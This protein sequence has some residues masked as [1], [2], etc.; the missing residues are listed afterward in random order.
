MAG[1]HP[2]LGAGAELDGVPTRKRTHGADGLLRG[3]WLVDD[4]NIQPG[5]LEVSE[6]L[7][8]VLVQGPVP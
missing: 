6:H 4:D 1:Q 3:H 5:L 7:I 8:D 2:A